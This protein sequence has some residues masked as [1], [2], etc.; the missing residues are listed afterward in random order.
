MKNILQTAS[1]LI[2]S[3]EDHIRENIARE[4]SSVSFY[5]RSIHKTDGAIV[6]MG[7]D[8]KERF[9]MVV[10]AKE[11]GLISEFSGEQIGDGGIFARKCPLNHHNAKIIRKYF[12]WTVPT[13]AAGHDLTVGFGDRIGLATLGH[14]AA[15]NSFNIFPVLAQQ[16][17]RELQMTGR[18]FF[19]VIDDVTFQVFEAGYKDGYGA[20]ADHL[21][22]I[23][24][25][26]IAYAAG[27]TFFTID[28]SDRI[29]VAA[30]EYDDKQLETAFAQLDKDAQGRALDK[31]SGKEFKVGGKKIAFTEK[32]AKLCAVLYADAIAFGIDAAAHLKS[33]DSRNH[34]LEIC[35]DEVNFSTPVEHHF[36]IARELHDNGVD[37]ATIAPSFSKDF[38]QAIAFNSTPEEF[39][40]IFALHNVVAEFFNSRLSVHSGS[41][42]EAL[43]AIIAKL[44]GG[45]FH[46]KISG[47]SWLEAV[48]LIAV[49]DPVLFKIMY[50]CARDNVERLKKFYNVSPD[51]DS[52]PEV[53]GVY[54]DQL[55]A[56]LERP[57]VTQMMHVGY[58]AILKD[59][60]IHPMLIAILHKT[61]KEYVEGLKNIYTG[62]LELMG[63]VRK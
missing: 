62:Y 3:H 38:E 57:A 21:K 30:L 34:D 14:V 55:T 1:G 26:E 8:Q 41:G 59:K 48:R 23:G 43:F 61:E 32:M 11:T 16:S 17:V 60:A 20:D 10:S 5:K 13:S 56:L 9:L 44:T 25:I 15:A 36:Y 6:S 63:A 51:I 42:K 39:G 35:F 47:T 29:K 22:T 54:D 2:D 4:E 46:I 31:Y 7:R 40:K 27:M 18:T 53:S 33:L 52:I 37:F 19:D 28:I 24:D 49:K 50:S 45:K 58:G 12:P